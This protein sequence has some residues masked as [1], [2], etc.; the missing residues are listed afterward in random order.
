MMRYVVF[1]L[2]C[3][4]LSIPVHAQFGGIK[5]PKTSDVKRA[6]EKELKEE[7]KEEP[8]EEKSTEKKETPKAEK[9][10]EKK[11]STT[12]SEMS[13][14]PPARGGNSR[15][16]TR[17]GRGAEP[18]VL[19]ADQLTP[20]KMDFIL[21]KVYKR[22]VRYMYT[23]EIMAQLQNFDRAA[24]DAKYGSSVPPVNG[25]EGNHIKSVNKVLEDY[26]NW[27][28]SE[29]V[30]DEFA[31]YRYSEAQNSNAPADKLK[32]YNQV[33][34]AC[35]IIQKISPNNKQ[36][37]PKLEEVKKLI[38]AVEKTMGAAFTSDYHR[39]HL[40]QMVFS[41]KPFKP[42]EEAKGDIRKS[43][44]AGETVYATMYLGR[45]V[46]QA[47]DSYAQQPIEIRM[48]GGLNGIGYVWVTTP[49][50]ENTFLQIAIIPGEDWLKENYKPYLENNE[51]FYQGFMENMAKALPIKHEL[52]VKFSFRA[53]KAEKF[54][55]AFTYDM[56]DGAEAMQ[57]LSSKL[58]S[59]GLASVK[60][61]AAGMTNAAL[62]KE[63]LEIC[64][65]KFSND[66]WY[67]VV[68]VSKDWKTQKNDL[69]GAILGR[70]VLAAVTY[71]NFGGECG[72]EYITFEQE[73]TGAGK[74][75]NTLRF[76]S[77]GGGSRMSCDN[78]K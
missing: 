59:Q 36:V 69:T 4:T 48:D 27:L 29:K 45:K 72:F 64:K 17:G 28:E 55:E 15:E 23:E 43:F 6:V 75:S 35:K 32:A 9:S 7:K 76:R 30:L 44:K 26:D 61:P 37:G 78:V 3:I 1:L 38:A 54:E 62:E 22:E 8:K 11:E 77:S 31:N 41:S 2:L 63:M 18:E 68:I 12:P 24:Y 74:Y 13:D 19:S 52:K 46:R 42:G 65:K 14:E 67:K 49:M 51:K 16:R 39:E 20:T 40:N 10:V 25:P 47:S 66:T 33:V 56:S 5:V 53:F 60:I 70:E 50:Q 34:T 73:Y 21:M 57:A 58:T 71:K